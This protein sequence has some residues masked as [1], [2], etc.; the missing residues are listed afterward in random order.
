MEILIKMVLKV[1]FHSQKKSKLFAFHWNSFEIV[2]AGTYLALFAHFVQGLRE[3]WAFDST[4]WFL[5]KKFLLL[6]L[7]WKTLLQTLLE[8]IFNEWFFVV[9][10]KK[11]FCFAW[12]FFQFLWC[13]PWTFRQY[14]KKYEIRIIKIKTICQALP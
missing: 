2:F 14:Y 6:E 7:S 8:L 9:W 5:T 10:L 11:H 1:N 3:M 13:F 4:R 12:M